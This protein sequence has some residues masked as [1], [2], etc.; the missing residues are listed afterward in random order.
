[1]DLLKSPSTGTKPHFDSSAMYFIRVLKKGSIHDNFGDDGMNS[2]DLYVTAKQT[3]IVLVESR[4]Y[5]QN[6]KYHG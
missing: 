6:P 3:T 1:M 2:L 5:G 4:Y